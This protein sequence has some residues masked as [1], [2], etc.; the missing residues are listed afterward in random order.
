VS[1]VESEMLTL[2]EV[3]I[4]LNVSSATVRAWAADGA[5]P[6]WRPKGNRR[7]VRVPKQALREWI[8]RDTVFAPIGDDEVDFDLD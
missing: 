5:I 1:T 3:S 8:A 7:I 2:E 4:F 6:T